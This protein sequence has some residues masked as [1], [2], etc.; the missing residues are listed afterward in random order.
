MLH[1]SKE[2]KAV[3]GMNKENLSITWRGE[4][5]ML[6]VRQQKE[7]GKLEWRK[8]NNNVEIKL[9]PQVEKKFQL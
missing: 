9:F 4:R 7:L 3:T 2:K 8:K 6:Q 1:E 5:F